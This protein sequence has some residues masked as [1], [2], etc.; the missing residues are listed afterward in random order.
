M[1]ADIFPMNSHSAYG[2]V[3]ANVCCQVLWS[4][5]WLNSSW[6]QIP[7]L[8]ITNVVLLKQI[9]WGEGVTFAR[10]IHEPAVLCDECPG[11]THQVGYR[12]QRPWRT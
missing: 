7:H 6:K 9:D 10:G 12:Q 1:E 11:N 4:L 2:P 8:N 5:G 3:A